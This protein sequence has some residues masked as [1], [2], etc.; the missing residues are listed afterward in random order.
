MDSGIFFYKLAISFA[1]RIARYKFEKFEIKLKLIK[2]Y[3][4]PHC[5]KICFLFH[6]TPLKTVIF[7]ATYKLSNINFSTKQKKNGIYT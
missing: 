4:I 1:R 5:A 3:N 6:E 2:Q 7:I